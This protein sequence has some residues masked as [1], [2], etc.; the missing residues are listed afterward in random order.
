MI[1]EIVHALNEINLSLYELT[2]AER[3][4][5]RALMD[6]SERLRELSEQKE[7]NT[8]NTPVRTLVEVSDVYSWTPIS[9]AEP[10]GGIHVLVTMQWEDGDLEV[11]EL[12]YG[13]LKATRWPHMDKVIAWAPLP[14][15]YKEAQP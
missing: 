9:T 6:V 2:A 4:N 8:L 13:L 10:P 3:N 7:R 12:D 5:G 11:A 15:P 1:K 14:E